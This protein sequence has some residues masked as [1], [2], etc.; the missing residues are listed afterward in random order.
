MPTREEVRALPAPPSLG[1]SLEPFL[2][3]GSGDDV[4]AVAE[5]ESRLQRALLVPEVVEPVTQAL[6]LDGDAAVVAVGKGVPELRPA[7]ARELDFLVDLGQGHDGANAPARPLIPGA[8]GGRGRSRSPRGRPR[9]RRPRSG[10]FPSGVAELVELVLVDSEVVRQLVE[11]GDADLLLEGIGVMAELFL[12]RPPVN[13][14]SG[15]QVFVLL[16]QTEEVGLLR[17]LVLDHEGHVL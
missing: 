12:E 11:D 10:P 3:P 17:V 4:V 14:D 5:A 8:P 6:E 9:P 16:E 1:G 2:D 7:L 13:R 15:G